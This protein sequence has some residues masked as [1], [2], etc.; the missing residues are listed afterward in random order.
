M[1]F[2]QTKDLKFT[3]DE[4]EDGETRQ[5]HEVLKG[6]N[7]EIKKGE[8][9][10]L[11]GHNGSGKSTIAKMFNAMLLPAGGRVYVEGMDTLDE[12]L[13]YEIRR[14]VGLVLQN[15]DNQLVAS[16][17]EEDV[18][19]GPE[20]LG[21][22]PEEIRRRVDD[23]LKAVE[24]YDYRLNAPY[25]LSGG[26]KQRIA[27]AGIIA[28]Q[29][30]CIV[31]DEPTAM[32]DPRGREEVLRTIHKLNQEKGITIVLITH[33]MDEA[34][35]AS[36]VVVMD[37]GQILLQGTPEEVF[38]HVE[39]LKKHKLDVPQATELIYRLRASG[40]PLPECVLNEEDCVAALERILKEPV[41][42]EFSGKK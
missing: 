5:V 6:V 19:F 26:Q 13:L 38:A 37:N 7:L 15:P 12:S 8:F 3:Y 18:A 40:Y 9:V 36:R 23:A 39:L 21:I 32:L 25:K 17:V 4:V 10:A 42:D 20:N 2:I 41:G 31:L 14:R 28:M 24:M 34:V 29:P 1:A 35:Q 11:L 16:I 27:I 30:E 33:Y 22:A